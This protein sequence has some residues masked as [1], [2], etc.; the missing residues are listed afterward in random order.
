M[1]EDRKRQ[2]I[3]QILETVSNLSHA[4]RQATLRY[5]NELC[6]SEPGFQ[7]LNHLTFQYGDYLIDVGLKFKLLAHARG[8]RRLS[9]YCNRK[10]HCVPEFVG[11]YDEMGQDYCVLFTRIPG[12]EGHRMLGFRD[13]CYLCTPQMRKKLLEDVDSFLKLRVV[14]MSLHYPETWYMLPETDTIY[15]GALSD[16]ASITDEIYD[17][18]VV[19]IPAK[20]RMLLGMG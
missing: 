6:A 1:S 3:E 17:K 16:L 12:L 18:A 13:Y 20:V 4:S 15:F 14:P 10:I 7:K 5:L 2:R 9:Q 19:M 8:V 11:M